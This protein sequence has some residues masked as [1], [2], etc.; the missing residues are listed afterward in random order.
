MAATVRSGR[1]RSGRRRRTRRRRWS[2]R[3]ARTA[4][5]RTTARVRWLKCTI[6]QPLA[7]GVALERAVGVDGHR[8]ADRLQ[9]RQVARRVAVGVALA[10]VE[11]VPAGD[12]LDR[13]DLAR[14][15]SRTA[16]RARRC[17]RRRRPRCGCRCP[18][19]SRA[20]GRAARRSPPAPPTR[21][22]CCARPGGAGRAAAAPRGGSCRA[23]WA[24][25]RRSRFDE[26]VLAQPG[27][28]PEDPVAH[29]VG[30]VVAGAEQLEVHGPC[31]IAHELRRRH[32]PGRPRRRGHHEHRRAGDQRA[33]EVEE[34]RARTSTRH[35]SRSRHLAMH[36]SSSSVRRLRP[37][38]QVRVGSGRCA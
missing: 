4:T 29:R 27:D 8:V 32:Q 7:A 18:P 20:P 28:R 1:G 24:A 22:R 35:C 33:V 17:T 23:A 16:R 21:C 3:R 12:L 6:G 14:G 36:E 26:V 2:P 38:A 34:R 19:S 13:L 31:G 10:E 9:H 5:R 15:R 25:P 37:G 11:P 30:R